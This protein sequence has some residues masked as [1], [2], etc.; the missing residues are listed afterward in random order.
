[1]SQDTIDILPVVLVM[2]IFVLSFGYLVVQSV[3]ARRVK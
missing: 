1:M 2:G 3:L